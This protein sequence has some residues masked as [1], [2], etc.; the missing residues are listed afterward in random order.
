MKSDNL[1][2]FSNKEIGEIRGFMKEGEPWFLAGQ[3]CRTLGI[4]NAS[5][6]VAD[7]K[8]RF[9]I[10][11]VDGIT[12]SYIML[13]DSMGRKQDN[14]IIPEPFLY[15]LIFRSRKQKAL[16][17]SAWITTEVLPSLRK[18]GEYRM[19]GKL[20]RK[21]L[22]ESIIFYGENERQHG[23]G[24]SNYSKL[25][26]KSLLL[27]PKNN[28]DSL[29]PEALEKIAHRENLVS[30]LLQEGKTYSDIKIVLEEL[31]QGGTI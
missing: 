7:V 9:S 2:T 30:A 6:A 16:R 27:P 4:K 14:L 31:S 20:I 17:F 29:A 13:E 19:Q 10:A 8:E 5:K 25:I 22:T 28:R 15:D 26:N 24:F 1:I 23:H 12:S 3:V 11:G 21:E 18:H